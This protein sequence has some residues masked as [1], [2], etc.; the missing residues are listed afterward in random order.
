MPDHIGPGLSHDVNLDIN[1][2]FNS[3]SHGFLF[4]IDSSRWEMLKFVK[5]DIDFKVN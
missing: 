2:S 3:Y 1:K 4:R 5:N